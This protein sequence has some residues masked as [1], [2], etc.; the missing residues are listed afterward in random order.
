MAQDQFNLVYI[1]ELLSKGQV[2]KLLMITNL[3][4]HWILILLVHSIF[5]KIYKY[6]HFLGDYQL[7]L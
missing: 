1:V 2:T 5:Y 3:M 6:N 4:S 7:Y